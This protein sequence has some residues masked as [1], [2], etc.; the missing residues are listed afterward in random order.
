MDRHKRFWERIA[1]QAD[2]PGEGFWGESIIEIV[3]DRQI[4]IENHQ[5][6][7]EYGHERICIR[8]RCG[9]LT[10][11]GKQLE[12]ARMTKELLVITGTID[13][14]ALQRGRRV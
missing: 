7:T 1:E 14:V 9:I 13:N 11:Y 4:L 5:G 2:L 8:L 6:V 3:G 12:L 10:V